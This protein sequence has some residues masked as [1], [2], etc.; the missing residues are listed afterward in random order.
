[1]IWDFSAKEYSRI[2]KDS[3]FMIDVGF[4][5]SW[6]FIFMIVNKWRS[7]TSLLQDI[8]YFIAN[9]EA[10]QNK[11]EALDLIVPNPNR[12]RQKLLREQSIIKQLFK[13]LHIPFMD[14]KDSPD[15]PWLRLDE[16]A[17]P[18]NA[19]YKYIFRLCYRIFRISFQDYRKNQVTLSK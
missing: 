17:D 14:V 18:K 3:S 19:P 15:G 2:C 16:L 12:D 1:M 8:I 4:L 5:V 10:E 6:M 11:A 9:L 7:V 13:I